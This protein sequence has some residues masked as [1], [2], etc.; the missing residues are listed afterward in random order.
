MK[1]FAVAL[2]AV[3]GGAGCAHAGFLD[4][5]SL[6]P[7]SSGSFTGTLDGIT[8]TGSITT[9]D[10]NNN[11][12]FNGVN[13]PSSWE[14]STLN[15]SSPQFSYNNIYT[16]STPLAD[17]IGYTSY[18]GGDTNATITITFSA[19]VTGLVFDVANVDGSQYNFTPTAG[20]GGLL[21][22][23]GNGGGGDGL[24]VVGNVVSD[25]NPYTE[26]GQDP[27]Q[28]PLT[29]G[30]RSAY[31]SV[32]L[33]GTFR[34]LTIDVSSP[35]KVGDGGSF[36]FAAAPEPATLAL[37]GIGLLAVFGFRRRKRS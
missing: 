22:L 1:A 28:Q 16:P 17:R 4:L 27:S 8:V 30:G 12:V 9:P 26:V 34:S 7:G 23:S 21:L 18:S 5:T 6:T 25:A 31:G 37:S 24:H 29:S 32:E 13:G 19:P 35:T 36:I 2:L 10:P 33:L 15:N 3:A 14:S 20:L 11:Y